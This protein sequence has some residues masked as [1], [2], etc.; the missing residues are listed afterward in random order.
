MILAFMAVGLF[1]VFGCLALD[2]VIP[3]APLLRLA[4]LPVRGRPASNGV[5]F[6]IS[7]FGIA[8]LAE[9]LFTG[10]GIFK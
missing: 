7:L 8:A 2:G 5:I 3:I 4:N 6:V 10:A 1:G 9:G